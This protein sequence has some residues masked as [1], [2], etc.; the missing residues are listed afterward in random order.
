MS[1]SVGF[2]C[3]GCNKILFGLAWANNGEMVIFGDCTC[4]GNVQRWVFLDDAIN[5]L[6]PNKKEEVVKPPSLLRLVK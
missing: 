6:G 3:S 4:N 1:R 5:T 2:E